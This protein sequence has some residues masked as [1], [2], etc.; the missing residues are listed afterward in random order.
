M[1]SASKSHPPRFASFSSE[2]A[3]GFDNWASQP[4]G[5]NISVLE[6][7]L[8]PALFQDIRDFWY[9]PFETDDDYILPQKNHAMRWYM[10]GKELDDICVQRFG[11]ALE[12]IRDSG[13]TTGEDILS[14][15][16]PR[17]P[18]DWLSI[19]LLLD[20]ISRNSYR[21]AKSKPVYGFFDPI[22]QGITLAAIEQGIPDQEPEIRW[23][24]AYRNWFYM[25]LMHSESIALHEKAIVEFGLLAKDVEHL[26]LGS[27]APDASEYEMRAREVVQGNAEAAKGVAENG[28][29]F[30]KK[31][32]DII[33]QFGRYPH[34]NKPLGR[35]PTVEETEYL[36]NGGETFTG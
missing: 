23:R 19:I 29:L 34:R 36:E 13:A 7:H 6:Q 1:S 21:G 30:E 22:A 4:Q 26:S 12:A 2:A 14:V 31:H 3:P 17:G 35:E 8:T 9:E 28:M 27:G 33:A 25:P 11:P 20:Q 24:F 15:V 32:K 16:Q 10:G 5:K 18:L